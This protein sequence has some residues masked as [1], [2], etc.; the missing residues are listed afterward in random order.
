MS[1]VKNKKT[2]NPMGYENILKL[3][4]TMSLP[5]MLSMLIQS[6]YNITDSYFVAQYSEKALRATSLSF[7]IQ[8][9]IIGFGVGTG[10]GINSYISR[11]LGS[12]NEEEANQGAM[13][14][15]LLA[16]IS[17]IIFLVF[18]I[19]FLDLFFDYFTQ[20]VQVKK[21]G[22]EYLGLISTFSF[23][24]LIQIIIEKTIQGTGNMIAPMII[25]LVGAIT[26]IILDPILIFG[27][28]GAPKMGIKGA[29]IATLIGQGAGALLGLF[30][31]L[32]GKTSIN[33]DFKRFSFSFDTIKNI[34]YVG[35]PSILMQSI[36]A[37][38]TS[39]LNLIV[40]THSELAV[41][42]LGIYLKLE[43]FILMPVFGLTQ[44]VMPLIGYNYGARNKDRIKKAHRY[45]IIIA[46]IIML[47]GTF[48]FQIFPRELLGIF[49]NDKE[50][51]DIGVYTL[52]I[53]SIGYV[54]AAIGILN[55]T[56]FQGL[57][58]GKFSLL[59]TVLR[60]FI[61]IIPLAYF[62]SKFGLNYVW[63]AYPIAEI[64]STVVS[65][66]LKNNVEKIYIDNL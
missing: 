13:H 49:T 29:A 65:Q 25:Q 18:R 31:I 64:V 6:L 32:T 22:M 60:Q 40:I 39:I 19:F 43:S 37:L 16:I 10:V 38:V 56:F 11:S 5:A 63:L 1:K 21:M 14:G 27:L 2:E 17:W 24:S 53:I 34:Y 4:I 20:D 33:I 57:G 7:P 8:I 36:S 44:G 51:I 42:V 66:I 48:I 46:M 61:I 26:N 47:I 59:I 12:G 54:F 45:G 28:L 62:L 9:I 23:L 3:I 15:L 52:R 55:S 30:I 35:F 41:S 50:M 58:V